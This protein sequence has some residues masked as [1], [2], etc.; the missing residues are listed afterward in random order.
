MAVLA[1]LCVLIGL[2]PL[3]VAPALD[4]ALGVWAAGAGTVED[5]APL[6]ALTAVGGS[7]I[8]LVGAVA[9]AVVPRARASAPTWGCGYPGSSPRIQYTASSFADTLVGLFAWVLAPIRRIS[10]VD[11][12]FPEPGA[13][14]T[15]VRDPALD[16]ALVPAAARLARAVSRLRGA[17]P[18]S[19]HWSLLYVLAA[20]IAL[21]LSTWSQS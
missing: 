16:L 13:L 4:G 15:A 7:L 10:T 20:V 8:A 3:S 9:L 17:Q 12:P 14:H 2:A 5:L 6:G 11:G 1:A 19:V 18:A 21:L